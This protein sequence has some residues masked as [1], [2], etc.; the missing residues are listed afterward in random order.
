MRTESDNP[1]GGPLITRR[2]A[3]KRGLAGI[4]AYAAA[5]VVLP[6][7]LFGR[8]APS[9]RINIG[10]IGNGLQCGGHFEY[11]M[12]RDDCRVVAL[13]DAFVAKAVKLRDGAEAAYGAAQPGG[14]YRGV[15]AYQHHEELLARDG[16]Y[17]RLVAT[18]TAPPA[19]TGS[20]RAA[21]RKPIVMGEEAGP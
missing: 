15:S 21:M 11:L 8:T 19:P 6:S 14:T 10:M 20:P 12:G 2:G 9:N 4:L 1:A 13:C 3:I 17:A 18:A 5:P 16:L 7:S